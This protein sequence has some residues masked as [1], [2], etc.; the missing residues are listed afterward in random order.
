M[1]PHCPPHPTPTMSAAAVPE[2]VLKKRR[3]LEQAK[4]QREQKL[5]ALRAKRKSQRKVIFVRAEKYLKEYRQ[6]ERS[7][8]R[9]RRLAKQG[10]NFFREPEARLAFVIRIRGINGVDPKTRKILQL[11][12]LRQIHNGVFVRLN[13]ATLKMLNLVEPYIAYGYPNLKSVKE[14]VYKR[15]FAKING[16]RIPIT[17]NALIEQHLGK[18]GIVCLEDIVHE[19]YAVGPHFKQVNKF[20]WPFKLSSPRGGYRKKTIHFVE[21]G[22]AGQRE[23]F[24]N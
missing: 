5:K 7:L 12:R 1:G 10:G 20:L 23:E 2:T 24:I 18:F 4:A 6:Q 14:L 16:Q 9:Q 11:L 17:C 8:I 21:G 19:I 13:K 3:S 15:G 22:D